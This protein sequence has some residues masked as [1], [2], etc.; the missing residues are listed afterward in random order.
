MKVRDPVQLK[1][2]I[3][4]PASMPSLSIQVTGF[5]RKETE[6][7]IAREVARCHNKIELSNITS[8]K[9]LITQQRSHFTTNILQLKPSRKLFLK[10]SSEE[11]RN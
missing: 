2:T 4:L 3:T 8:V 9:K 10:T 1:K 11:K 5:N 6:L 7:D